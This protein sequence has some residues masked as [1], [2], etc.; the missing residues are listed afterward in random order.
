MANIANMAALSKGGT[1]ESVVEY[2]EYWSPKYYSRCAESEI[3]SMR[4][5]HVHFTKIQNELYSQGREHV[6]L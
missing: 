1:C 2:T 5:K 3:P 6:L 4:L